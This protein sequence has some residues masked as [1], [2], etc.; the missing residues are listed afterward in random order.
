MKMKIDAC[1]EATIYLIWKNK[2][3][4][5]AQQLLKAIFDSNTNIEAI[6]VRFEDQEDIINLKESLNLK[7]RVN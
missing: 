4:K 3:K 6:S 7:S 5:E 1:V 2:D